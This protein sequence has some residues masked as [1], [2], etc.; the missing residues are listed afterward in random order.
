MELSIDTSTR[1]AS[2]AISSQGGVTMELTWRSEQNHSAEL[3]PTMRHLIKQADVEMRQIEAIFVAKGPGGFSA[4]RVGISVAKALA[5]AQSIPLVAIGTLDIEAQP[6]LGLGI[7]LCAVIGAGRRLV[8]SAFYDAQPQATGNRQAEYRVETPE[9]L[10]SLVDKGMMLC[11]EGTQAVF[12]V[13]QQISG[14]SP[15]V[16]DAHPPT[17]RPGALA[18]LGYRRLQASD[19][20]DPE[21]LRPLYIHGSQFETAQPSWAA[22]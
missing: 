17:R 2:V 1:Y 21:T 16:V 11:G 9:D 20:D 7:P 8:Y 12:N 10:A 3:V 15:L 19:T 4:L 18:L 14:T 22:G 13:L 5:M 6:Y